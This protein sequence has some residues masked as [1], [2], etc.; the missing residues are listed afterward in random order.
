M[1]TGLHRYDPR[2]RPVGHRQARTPLWIPWWVP[3]IAIAVLAGTAG[4]V[5]A[6]FP[7]SGVPGRLSL[8]PAVH[9]TPGVRPSVS[10]GVV[11]E[12]PVDQGDDQGQGQGQQ[13]GDDQASRSTPRPTSTGI[14]DP[15]L[16][17]AAGNEAQA[18]PAPLLLPVPSSP[19]PMVVPSPSPSPTAR[20]P[21]RPKGL[22]TQS[23]ARH[24]GIL[25]AYRAALLILAAIF[26]DRP[27]YREEWRP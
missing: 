7:A 23:E 20:G 21:A 16:A 6:V 4:M 12:P 5:L 19:P 17:P 24:G 22:E 15:P 1:S 27:G 10:E 8:P 2:L 3:A 9:A 18:T 13:R 26:A 14:A 11:A 25:D